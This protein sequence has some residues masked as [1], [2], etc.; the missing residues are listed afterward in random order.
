MNRILVVEDE[1]SIADMIK[2]CLG[3]TDTYVKS[4]RME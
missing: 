1:R 3:K 4:H 2:M